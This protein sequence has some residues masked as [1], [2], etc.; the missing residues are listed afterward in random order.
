MPQQR[1]VLNADEGQRPFH[2][3]IV[4]SLLEKGTRQ[5]LSQ[6]VQSIEETRR[7][8]GA[9]G[10]TC[11]GNFERITFCRQRGIGYEADIRRWR[12]RRALR[13]IQ[14][15]ARSGFQLSGKT[16]GMCLR[17]VIGI[18]NRRKRAHIE[19]TVLSH[20]HRS[21]HGYQGVFAS[22]LVFRFRNKANGV[23][24]VAHV[25]KARAPV[26]GRSTPKIDGERSV[27]GG[28]YLKT[29]GISR[30]RAGND[31]EQSL[32]RGRSG[33]H[34]FVFISPGRGIEFQTALAGKLIAGSGIA[35][36]FEPLAVNA[37]RL[38]DRDFTAG[39]RG[40]NHFAAVHKLNKIP[41]LVLTGADRR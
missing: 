28:H 20:L 7:R 5:E 33:C 4:G 6:C 32:T 16:L 10:D 1:R 40:V 35:R 19:S 14:R 13:D 3:G 12:L 22:T 37:R 17:L 26:V 15:N 38:I 39:G 34:Q 9:E 25:P 24:L 21:G 30:S 2:T 31:F 29:I 11:I 41:H 27:A 36:Q 18:S 23:V 8:G